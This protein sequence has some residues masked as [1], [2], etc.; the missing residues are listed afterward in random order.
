[1]EDKN[2]KKTLVQ[3]SRLV[4]ET[5]YVVVEH[6]GEEPDLHE[7]YEAE[8]VDGHW[9]PDYEWGADEG[10]HHVVGDA[11]EGETYPVVKL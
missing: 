1:M 7:V 10:T 3:L 6:E 4:R 8:D 11:P 5:A 2:T 9:H